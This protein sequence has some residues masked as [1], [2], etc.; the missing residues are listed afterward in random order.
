MK[1]SR[2]SLFKG[3]I[4]TVGAYGISLTTRFMTN[5]VLTR[6][7]APELFGI[8]T[9]VNSIRSGVELLSDMGIRQSVVLNPESEKPDFYN[10]AWT[11]NLIRGVVLWFVCSILA[12]P[13]AHFYNLPILRLVL[14]VY[15]LVCVIAGLS[16]VGPY[17]LNKKMQLAKFNAFDAGTDI[18]SSIVHVT[19][20]Y[21]NPTIWALVLAGLIGFLGKSIGSYFMVPE[22]KHRFYF[23]KEYASQ[24]LRFGKWIF[25]SS[26][27]FF[28]SMNID[29]LYM[30]KIIPL[31]L[32][33]IYGIARTFSD[34]CA[35]AVLRLGYYVIFPFITSNSEIPRA[36]LRRKLASTR[37][38]FML[39]TA[40]GISVFSANT[41]LLIKIL[42]DQRYQS[43]GWMLSILLTGSWFT[44]ICNINESTLLG[45]GVPRYGAI[46]NSLKFGWLLLGLPIGFMTF[47]ILGGIII[48]AT[49]DVCRYIP[50]FAGQARERF[51]FGMQDLAATVAMFG[52]IALW[53]WL[54]WKFGLGI[55]FT[56]MLT[57]R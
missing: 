40:F 4:W 49:S 30:G 45:F 20:V 11:I 48:V 50:I 53:E 3:A 24:I 51:S 47:G 16:S 46:A 17:F 55:S 54:R 44:I 5:I 12:F 31:G 25:I 42:Y 41:D 39:I 10:T 18:I 9:I 33:G 6:F 26:F 28:F 15:A 27:I 38:T 14:P 29:R 13:L 32:F 34:L 8:M 19:L 52:L 22:I 7:L 56:G 57:G 21:L 23:S 1:F 43:V 37:L 2:Y 35:T 36:D